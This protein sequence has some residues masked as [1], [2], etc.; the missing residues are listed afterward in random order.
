MSSF[1]NG[2]DY[3]LLGD[4]LHGVAHASAAAGSS[5]AHDMQLNLMDVETV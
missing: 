1:L 2:M 5:P 4:I 3:S